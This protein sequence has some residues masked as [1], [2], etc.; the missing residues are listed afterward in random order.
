MPMRRLRIGSAVY[1]LRSAVCG[2]DWSPKTED[3]RLSDLHVQTPDRALHLRADLADAVLDAAVDLGT[4]EYDLVDR[5]PPQ[6]IL[7]RVDRPAHRDA[8]DPAVRLHRVVVEERDRVHVPLRVGAHLSH[9]RLA[10]GAGAV[11]EHAPAELAASGGDEIHRPERRPRGDDGNRQQQRV[12]YEYRAREPFETID[13]S[14]G[15]H[16]QHRSH[17][18]TADDRCNVPES[19]GAQ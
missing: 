9:E 7:E 10:E 2:P 6:C 19:E 11:D 18:D 16:R 14:D 15:E 8:R 5:Q 3:R 12:E 13:V 4:T 17:T 1:G